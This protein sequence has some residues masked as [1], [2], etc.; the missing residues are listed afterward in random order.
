M[1][2]LVAEDE[3]YYEGKGL[4]ELKREYGVNDIY[5]HPTNDTLREHL[6]MQTR[7]KIALMA[8][9]T[10]SSMDKKYAGN[11]FFEVV[12]LQNKHGFLTT[13][14]KKL[15]IKEATSLE[16]KLGVKIYE[17]KL[18][19]DD[20]AGASVLRESLHIMEEKE[21]YGLSVKGFMIA[22]IPGTGK[23]FF[24][25]CAAGETGRKLVELNLSMFMEME[26]GL[27]A[28]S[29]FFDFFVTNEGR[30]I[31][32]IDE[33]EKMFVGDRAKQM[34][35]VLLTRINDLNGSNAKSSFF[36]IATANN[37]SGLAKT[38]PEFFRN[39]RF[40]V[41]AFILN[42]TQ[43]NAENIFELYIRKH[44][45]QFKTETLPLFFKNAANGEKARAGTKAEEIINTIA[46]IG[47]KLSKLKEQST[48][49]ILDSI[50]KSKELTVVYEEMLS[51]HGFSF[52]TKEFVL[53]S[54][55]VYGESSVMPER[56]THTPAEIEYVIQDAFSSFYFSTV[57]LNMNE[58][59][60]KYQPLQVTM[61]DAI[62]AMLGNADKFIRI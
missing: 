14:Q 54:I 23:S 46:K 7:D 17:P 30:Y 61:K 35:G 5:M 8:P 51:L 57:K 49:E 4:S 58:L 32:W 39:G 34:L 10:P 60:N 48:S 24:A 43:E 55:R 52:A 59:V 12:R 37:I 53:S 18:N 40:D 56:Y 29:V 2:Y 36:F 33:I 16:E 45:K 26:D 19:F 25:K 50:H 27:Q 15:G 44:I 22:G 31:I 13:G 6:N 41:L 21:R 62:Q 9:Y 47:N 3:Y 42:P 38:N 20:Y 11:S 1:L 28:L